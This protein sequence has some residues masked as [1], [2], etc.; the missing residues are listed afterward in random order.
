MLLDT[1]TLIGSGDDAEAEL[2]TALASAGV[3]V[4]R[5]AAH[6]TELVLIAASVGRPVLPAALAA[7]RPDQ[8]VGLHLPGGLAPGNLAELIQTSL[9]SDAAM[10]TRP[11]SGGQ[12]RPRRCVRQDR[13][14]LPGRGLIRIWPTL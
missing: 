14:E 12:A 2:A 13:P 8:S 1:V 3:N 7:G 5:N 9:S 11:R 10:T 4:T 6:P